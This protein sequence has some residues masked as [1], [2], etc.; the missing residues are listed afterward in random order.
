M[1]FFLNH[2]DD[3]VYLPLYDYLSQEEG[4]LS[5]V[6]VHVSTKNIVCCGKMCYL[7]EA[8]I[9]LPEYDSDDS[10][11]LGSP[12]AFG[13]R[14][15]F[16][17][18]ADAGAVVWAGHLDNLDTTGFFNS[19]SLIGL[20]QG[21]NEASQI[22]TQA[23]FTSTASPTAHVIHTSTN[24]DINFREID[25]PLGQRLVS[26]NNESWTCVF[27]TAIVTKSSIVVAESY[28]GSGNPI[29]NFR[30]VLTFHPIASLQCQGKVSPHPLTLE[31]EGLVYH[32]AP[33]GDDHIIALCKDNV[34][35]WEMTA[36]GGW[37]RNANENETLLTVLIHVPSR[38]K[39]HLARLN[40]FPACD[41]SSVLPFPISIVSRDSTLAV[42][43]SKLGMVLIGDDMRK[44]DGD[45][46]N[47]LKKSKKKKQKKASRGGKKDGFARGL[48]TR[49]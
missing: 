15:I 27:H 20:Q 11:I 24:G 45:E 28:V 22:H 41:I 34:P 49:G 32:L 35:H 31:Q 29:H 12:V 21:T 47:G 13:T 26:V 37:H 9:M 42:C 36:E 8:A 16:M 17:F 1:D 43:T 2:H 44:S 48:S 6:D 10:D 14:K 3:G 18:S 33:I 5:L 19:S 38:Q 39:M 7:F 25:Q 46:K 4:D 30:A 23:V 40:Y